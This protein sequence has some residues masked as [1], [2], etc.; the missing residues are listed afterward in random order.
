[1]PCAHRCLLGADQYMA[2]R[3]HKNHLC[4]T[5]TRD[6]LHEIWDVEAKPHSF[7]TQEVGP[8]SRKCQFSP[9]VC[10][11]LASALPAPAGPSPSLGLKQGQP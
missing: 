1:M 10:S 5:V 11:S 4:L 8:G 3:G 7:H 6:I 2:Q 9:T